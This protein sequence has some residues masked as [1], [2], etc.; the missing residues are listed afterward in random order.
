M[1]RRLAAIAVLVLGVASRAHADV[2]LTI[3]NDNL[4]LVKET[5][6]LT[7]QKG[8]FDLPFTDVAAAIDPT[9][10]TFAV[11]D[12]PGAVT[13][14][15]QNYRFDLVSSDKLLEK[16][17]DRAVR[18]I[19]KQDKVHEGTLLAADGAALTLKQPDGALSIVNRAEIADLSL[20]SLPEGL[21]T[22]PTLVWKLRSDVAGPARSEVRYLTG[23]INWQAQYI[24]T[25]NA[26]ED[27]LDLS[28]WVSIDNRSGATYTDA[29]LKLMAGDVHRVEPPRPKGM[30]MDIA[31]ARMSAEAGFEEKSFFEY[32]LYTLSRPATVR[33]NEIKQLA[34]FDPAHVK[35]EK[36]YTYDGARDG[37][38][39]RVTME[40]TNS[41]AAGLGMPLPAGTI[42]VMKADT[43]GSWEFVGEDR[44]DHTPK[45]EKLRPFLGYAFDIVGERTQM[46]R[47]QIS[48]RVYDER[49]E[50]KLRNH[51]TAAVTIVVVEHFWGDWSISESSH[52]ATK[53]DARTAEWRIPVAPDA[54][55]VLTFTVRHRN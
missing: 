1:R 13:L 51:K 40:F 22:R 33:D 29:T 39:V 21:I 31:M 35:A 41:Q 28:G 50:I 43:D 44:I 37:A 36:I 46:D 45:D 9:S 8:T 6:L 5:R 53:K 20:T 38:K 32:H 27:G 25:V 23:K 12:N 49:F 54:E 11:L 2:Q 16:Y 52:T 48:P 24:A 10:V 19:T 42:R 14:L 17:I 4:A 34:L 30:G 15:E 18:V 47:Q 7:L 26:A 3:Y 55:S